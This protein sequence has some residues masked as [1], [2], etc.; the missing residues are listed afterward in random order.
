MVTLIEI[1]KAIN[2]KIEAALIGT[3]FSEVPLLAEDISEAIKRPSIKVEIDNPSLG[4]FNANCRERNLTCRV[5]FFAKDRDK[6]KI[7]NMKMQEILT[8]A[9]LDGLYVSDNFF[10]PID[11][12][13]GDVVDGV[14]I[15]SFDLYA[16]ELV[17]EAT[18]NPA[19][20]LIEPME[21]LDFKG[22]KA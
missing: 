11:N 9:L 16:V 21:E 4:N 13:E 19:G 17:P 5:Y 10:I 2:S 8:N 12:V 3:P 6:F 18:M 22:V 20:E 14:L 1:N 15:C 7:D